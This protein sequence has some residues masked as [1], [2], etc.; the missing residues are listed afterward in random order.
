MP[1]RRAAAGLLFALAT[2]CLD[3]G[4]PYLAVEDGQPPQVVSTNVDLQSDGRQQ[5]VPRDLNIEVNFSELM[6]TDTFRSG[7]VVVRRG[8][9]EVESAFD[10]TEPLPELDTDRGDDPFTAVV[11]RP[12]VTVWVIAEGGLT[13]GFFPD[14][15]VADGG[16]REV[17]VLLA[18][19]TDHVLLLRTLLT[20]TEGNPL[21]EE[22]QRRFRTSLQ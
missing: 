4:R 13:T 15:G 7:I 19:N 1:V 17:P 22:V 18:P 9:E 2:G 14:G 6:D 11:A 10:L 5:T 3:V 8:G 21:A 20:D 16:T 12:K